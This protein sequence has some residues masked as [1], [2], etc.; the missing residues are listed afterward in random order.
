MSQRELQ[1]LSVIRST[2]RS[3]NM[4]E[5]ADFR[6]KPFEEL[7]EE[8]IDQL[9]REEAEEAPSTSQKD[10]AWSFNRSFTGV[11]LRYG[12]AEDY[13]KAKAERA[14]LNAE[15]YLEKRK[16]AMHYIAT[17]TLFDFDKPVDGFVLDIVK[18]L[19]LS[20]QKEIREAAYRKLTNMV[21]AIARRMIPKKLIDAY[22]LFPESLIRMEGV[23]LSDTYVGIDGHEKT[24]NA[25]VEL[26][27][28]SALTS[29]DIHDELAR[30]SQA[31]EH[32]ALKLKLN[33][34]AA[35]RS[36]AIYRRKSFKM[37]LKLSEIRRMTYGGFAN[38]YPVTF[39]NVCE[40]INDLGLNVIVE[41]NANMHGA[42][43]KGQTNITPNIKC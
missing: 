4:A 30:M 20:R 29:K 35:H 25:W 17:Q 33:I 22:E 15:D 19:G 32:F 9:R 6:D 36:A 8:E 11:K 23:H 42:I 1:G 12:C 10:G 31:N 39:W 5:Y 28:P 40:Y 38:A 7:T 43:A 2:Q 13:L 18:K 14:N 27:L 41:Q 24:Y 16:E 34:R 26:E 37:M 3:S 21:Y